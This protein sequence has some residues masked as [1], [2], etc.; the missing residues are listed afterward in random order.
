MALAL[1]GA[2][3][4]TASDGVV[5]EGTLLIDGRIIEAVGADVDV[6]GTPRPGTCAARCSFR[7]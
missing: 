2:C 4:M 1:V 6:P 3:I 5:E 7:G